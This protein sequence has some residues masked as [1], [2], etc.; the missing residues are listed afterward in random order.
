MLPKGGNPF[1]GPERFQKPEKGKENRTVHFVFDEVTLEK[2]KDWL[3]EEDMPFKTMPKT[4][5]KPKDG[6]L[7][8]FD[9]QS[10]ALLFRMQW[11]DE[12]KRYSKRTGG[13]T[14]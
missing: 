12:D 1:A 3:N 9:E 14:G 10:D 8:I 13:K 2:A 5:K 4:P 7:F 11:E 6:T